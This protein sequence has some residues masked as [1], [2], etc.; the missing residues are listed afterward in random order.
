[1]LETARGGML[2]AGLG[3]DL[4]DVAVVT[5]IGEGDHLGLAY[6]DNL[7]TLAKV[8]RAI[9][10]VVMPTGYAV[11]NAADPLVAEMAAKCP[12]KVVFF[13][14]DPAQSVLAAHR[15]NG[16]RAIFVRDG[17][18]VIA[19]GAREEVVISLD[20]VPLTHRGRIGF[21]VE[22]ALAAI[23]AA[24]SLGVP[25]DVIR[26]RVESFAADLDTVARPLQ[27]AGDPTAPLVVI[28][29][30]HNSS[31]LLALVEAVETAAAPAADDR[32]LHR[33]RPPRL[34]HR[35]PGPDPRPALRSA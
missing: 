4:C 10:D 27:P 8:K 30:G 3:F 21:Q 31:A 32:L 29:Y 24:W 11:L 35:P 12:G 17:A 15:Q 13:A 33:R 6:V 25:L 7:E 22:N 26:T 9:V 28:D 16:G 19:D 2:R 14:R 1:M 20:R 5:N 18:I 34:R 23:A